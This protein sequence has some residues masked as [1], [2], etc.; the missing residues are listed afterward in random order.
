MLPD[1][2]RYPNPSSGFWVCPAV[3]S[4]SDVSGKPPMP[5]LTPSLKLSPALGGLSN[6]GGFYLQSCSFG[7]YPKLATVGEAVNVDGQAMSATVPL[8]W[9]ARYFLSERRG[10]SR[11][12]GLFIGFNSNSIGDVSELSPRFLLSGE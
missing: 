5:A 4:Q 1:Q 10:Q 2:M 11:S 3:S 6:F 9:L 7:H 12:D 8:L